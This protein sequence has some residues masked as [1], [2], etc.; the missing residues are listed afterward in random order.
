MQWV[1]SSAGGR[2]GEPSQNPCATPLVRQGLVVSGGEGQADHTASSIVAVQPRSS[3][4][5]VSLIQPGPLGEA[6]SGG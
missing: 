5:P 6:R 1:H 3:T 4:P 2:P